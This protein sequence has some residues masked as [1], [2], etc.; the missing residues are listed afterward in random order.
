MAK[1]GKSKRPHLHCKQYLGMK[2]RIKN[3]TKLLEKRLEK[4]TKESSKDNIMRSCRIGRKKEGFVQEEIKHKPQ[5][6]Q[7]NG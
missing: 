1:G 5:K 2:K 4:I 6:R 7:I 3:K